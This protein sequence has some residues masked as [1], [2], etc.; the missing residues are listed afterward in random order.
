MFDN[1]QETDNNQATDENREIRRRRR[2]KDQRKVYLLLILILLLIAGLGFVI[3]S[4]VRNEILERNQIKQEAVSEETTDGMEEVETETVVETTETVTEYTEEELLDEIVQTCIN[5]MPLEDK[6]AGLFVITPEALTGVDTVIKAGNTTKEALLQYPVGGL[7]YFKQNIQSKEQ[8]TEMLG[9]TVAMSKY[10]IFLAVDEEGGTVARVADA[11]GLQK[12]KDAMELGKE[13]NPEIVKEAYQNIGKY[14]CEM[15]FNVDFAPVSDI[16]S[17]PDN[18]VIAKRAFGTDT[19]TV[20]KMV[21]AAVSALEAEGITSCLKHFPGQ[22]N[23][24]VDTHET[25]AVSN[26]TLE[27]LREEELKPFQ[28]GIE[29]GAQ[30]I[31]VGHFAVPELT[32]EGVPASLSKEVMTNL[33]RDEMGYEGVIVTDALNMGAI[34]EKQDSAEVCISA[35]EA[36]ADLLLMP[37]DFKTAYEGVLQAVKDGTISEA[38]VNDSLTRIYKIKYKNAIDN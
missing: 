26:R 12:T 30:M 15:G 7:I 18:A 33:L 19:E 34:T 13:G 20:S 9:T 4:V 29:A 23:G 11:L 31:M 37:Q 17:N 36:G 1:N 25:L 32:G 6:V 35:L 3:I 8:I 38:R 24:N 2:K 16:L 22:G 27:E 21:P 28:A 10:P 5:D 14:L